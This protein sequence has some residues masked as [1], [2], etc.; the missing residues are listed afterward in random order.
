MQSSEGED[1]QVPL[2]VYSRR[3]QLAPE[4]PHVPV[5]QPEK[6]TNSIDLDAQKKGNDFLSLNDL[7]LPIALRKEKRQCT[8]HPL[9]HF[10]SLEKLSPSYQAFVLKLNSIETPKIVQEALR[11]DNWRK[12]MRE[13]MSALIKTNTWEVMDLPI[14]KKKVDC[15]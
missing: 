6:G 9:S 4:T 14:G 7:D 10:V 12:E 15:K 3:K 1:L 11:N 8:Q 5:I 13:E 2:K